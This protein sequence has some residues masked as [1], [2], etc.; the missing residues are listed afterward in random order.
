MLANT[1]EVSSKMAQPFLTENS[2]PAKVGQS[3]CLRFWLH[4]WRKLIGN[5]H[6]R[7]MRYCLDAFRLKLLIGEIV[8]TPCGLKTVECRLRVV[9]FQATAS[10]R[11]VGLA[12]AEL[13]LSLAALR[14]ARQFS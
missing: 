14:S 13:P 6:I 11:G 10:E 1:S 9:K 5:P 2:H 8:R 7:I 12:L 3:I 4:G